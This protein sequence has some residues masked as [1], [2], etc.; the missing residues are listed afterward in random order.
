MAAATV[1]ALGVFG[2]S[3]ASAAT[4]SVCESGCAYSSIQSAINAAS[5]GDKIKIAPGS[6]EE[7]L[8]I[9][10]AGTATSLILSGAGAAQTTIS[11][12]HSGTVV[13]IAGGESVAIAGIT[14]TAG[15][16]PL[17]NCAGIAGGILNDGTL[18]LNNSAV[19]ENK[20][21]GKGGGI[22]NNSGSALTVDNS[23]IFDNEADQHGGGG[24]GGGCV[25]AGGGIYNN[26]GTVRLMNSTV[27]ESTTAGKGSGIFNGSGG[28]LTMRNATILDNEAHQLGGGIFNQGNVTANNGTFT[29][30]IGKEGGGGI[31]STGGTVTLTNIS[32]S[33]NTGGGVYNQG[34]LRLRHSTISGNGGGQGIVNS[35]STTLNKTTVSGNTEGGIYNGGGTLSLRHSAVNENTSF[36]GAGAGIAN[37]SGMLT[38]TGSTV[39]GNTGH[40]IGGGIFN[41]ANTMISNST[42]SDNVAVCSY[43][44]GGGMWTEVGDMTIT[45]STFTGNRSENGGAINEAGA[46]GSLT[47]TDSTV[48]DN[49]AIK[50]GGGLDT[51]RVNL[52]NTKITDNYGE[53]GGGIFNWEVVKGSG[54]TITGNT[55]LI[56]PGIFNKVGA[57][58]ELTNSNVQ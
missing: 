23:V 6:Y 40:F 41:K 12:S 44:D 4:L 11:G 22:Y 52:I 50:E 21:S 47:L 48:S 25:G 39:S 56:E 19:S 55:A 45:K 54:D 36:S 17:A 46:G 1:L 42:I 37:W 5:T 26:S 33:A 49:E 31:F 10:G 14:I 8:K 9:P 35:G 28:T 7:H 58:V 20:A 29:G 57:V 53:E 2:S 27:S 34:T 18:K 16:E 24:G 30:N 3:A 43:C 13:T 51:F 32:F 15:S 38:L